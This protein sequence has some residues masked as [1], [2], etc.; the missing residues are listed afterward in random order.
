MF[1]KDLEAGHKFK[2]GSI[3]T[4]FHERHIARCYS[5]KMKFYRK[6]FTISEDHIVLCDLSRLDKETLDYV[7]NVAPHNIPVEE[8]IHFKKEYNGFIV[9]YDDVTKW[10]D[11]HLRDNLYWLPANIAF[12]LHKK[13]V[14]VRLV[15]SLKENSYRT[16]KIDKCW[17]AGEKECFCIST[18]TTRY[19]VC[20]VVSHNSV[21]LRNVTYHA[22]THSDDIKLCMVDLKFSEFYRYKEMNNVVGVANTVR[23]AAELLRLCREVMQKRNKQ[24][25]E[26]GLTDFADYKPTKATD[27][28]SIYGREFN[29]DTVFQVEVGGE[30]KEMTAKE[31]LE[32]VESN[33][34]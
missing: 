25:A 27:K 19:E 16:R 2:D 29:E 18:D 26:R 33:Y 28:V 8:D 4:Q 30:K 23:E 9:E 24:N 13:R 21:T 5:F 10:D 15:H 1:W 32:W 20:G 6:P 17:Y 11:F 3:L 14:D 7:Y 31:I 34:K 22:L 12:I